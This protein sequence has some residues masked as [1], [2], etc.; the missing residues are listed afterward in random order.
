MSP[1]P[2]LIV[3]DLYHMFHLK[4]Q[5][6]QTRITTFFKSIRNSLRNHLPTTKKAP[7]SLFSSTP[8]NNHSNSDYRMRSLKVEAPERYVSDLFLKMASG[9]RFENIL[10]SAS[11]I[12]GTTAPARLNYY[13][14]HTKS[15]TSRRRCFKKL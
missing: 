12:N 10:Y 13:N 8:P 2:Y 11:P 15:S 3:H 6:H 7:F 4:K 9:K 1:K 14:V 5:P